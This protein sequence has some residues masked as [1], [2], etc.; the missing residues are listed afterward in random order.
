LIGLYQQAV[1]E[2]N[3]CLEIKPENEKVT[4]ALSELHHELGII[5]SKYCQVSRDSKN[6]KQ[7]TN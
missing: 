6:V 5:N 1:E 4:Q 7:I 3:K 2:W